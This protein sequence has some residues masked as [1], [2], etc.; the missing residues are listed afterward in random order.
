MAV[1]LTV[2][3]FPVF[4]ANDCPT[5]L[6]RH[7]ETHLKPLENSAQQAIKTDTGLNVGGLGNLFEPLFPHQ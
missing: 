3:D 7:N 1:Q 4:P 6:E 2:D 5:N